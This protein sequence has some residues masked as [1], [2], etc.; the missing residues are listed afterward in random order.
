MP[1][2]LPLPT[3]SRHRGGDLG[4]LGAE[5]CM[6]WAAQFA[7]PVP[8]RAH[9][10]PLGLCGQVL[11]LPTKASAW[12]SRSS[13]CASDGEAAEVVQA[14][15]HMALLPM[16]D[17]GPLSRPLLF[18]LLSLHWAQEGP[19]MFDILSCHLCSR[20]VVRL[21]WVHPTPRLTRQ[22]LILWDPSQESWSAGH[23]NELLPSPGVRGLFLVVWH[24]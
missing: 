19:L 21:Q 8:G 3:Q 17:A 14:R 1:V 23:V 7:T 11:P 22:K 18:H 10:C 24:S 6:V 5:S 15:A 16:W 4:S 12:T 9:P 20:Q 2:T 13:H